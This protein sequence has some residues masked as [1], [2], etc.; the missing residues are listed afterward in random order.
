MESRLSALVVDDYEP[1]REVVSRLVERAGY[2]V[3]VASD[4]QEAVESFSAH[5]CDLVVMDIDMPRMDGLLALHR[6]RQLAPHVGALI[7]TGNWVDPSR[8]Q[9]EELGAAFIQK[10]FSFADFRAMLELVREQQARPFV[11]SPAAD[12]QD[13]TEPGHQRPNR[14]RDRRTRASRLT[15]TISLRY[16]KREQRPCAILNLG[17][18]GSLNQFLE[19]P[20][21]PIH[22]EVDLSFAPLAA[23]GSLTVPGV[24]AWTDFGL[25]HCGTRF[26]HLD[27]PQWRGLQR[28]VLEAWRQAWLP[29]WS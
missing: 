14:R 12:P 2:E 27:E 6:I 11:T 23:G 13:Q 25:N 4:G 1:V 5:P 10:P 16:A 3:R 19:H 29:E 18:G 28:A 7:M 8:A 22:S 15:A 20:P 21:F 9:A 17:M 26:L 24:V